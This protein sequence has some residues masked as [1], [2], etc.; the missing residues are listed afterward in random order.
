MNLTDLSFCRISV[1]DLLNDVPLQLSWRQPPVEPGL[2]LDAIDLWA[3]DL[4]DSRWQSAESLRVLNTEERARAARF[5]FERDRHQFVVRHAILRHVLGWYL[6]VP[7]QRIEF[8]VSELGKPALAGA[9]AKAGLEFNLSSSGPVAVY[10]VARGRHTGVDVEVF[11]PDFNWSEVSGQ[12]FHPREASCLREAPP[13]E[14]VDLFFAFWTMKEAFVK[15]R[16]LGLQ[17][18][19]LETDLTAVVRDGQGSFTDVDG[20]RWLWVRFR[21]GQN[22]RAAVV[23]EHKTT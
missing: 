3:A 20:G 5:R 7:A 23:V 2:P 22:S 15:A 19:L 18:P 10:A 1:Q 13:A 14:Q 11:R 17:Q 8:S 6:A 12:F 9:A 16:G 4:D 21:V